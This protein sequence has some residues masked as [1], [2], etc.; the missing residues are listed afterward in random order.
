[1]GLRKLILHLLLYQYVTQQIASK[2]VRNNGDW[3][4]DGCC[5]ECPDLSDIVPASNNQRYVKICQHGESGNKSYFATL[6][7]TTNRIPVFSKFIVHG[8]KNQLQA[9]FKFPF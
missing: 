2:I 7:D 5:E 8:E 1:M 9:L 6:F 4:A 3:N